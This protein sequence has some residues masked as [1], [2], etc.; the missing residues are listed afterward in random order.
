MNPLELQSKVR[1]NAL[2]QQSSIKELLQWE[3]EADQRDN[4]LKRRQKK[5]KKAVRSTSSNLHLPVRAGGGS[6]S[7][8]N[9]RNTSQL[10]SDEKSFKNSKTDQN[11]TAADHT[12]DKL[13]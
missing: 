6:I 2:E 1:H 11:K 10:T 3:K 5:Q 8:Q 9:Q 4:S 7:I 12:Y 13:I